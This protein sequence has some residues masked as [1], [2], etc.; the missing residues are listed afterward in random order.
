MYTATL[1]EERLAP[2]FI[3]SVST[4]K[5]FFFIK[6]NLPSMTTS[7]LKLMLN[8]LLPPTTKSGK[9]ISILEA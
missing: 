1:P 5:S 6:K 7:V 3:L 2:H 8:S 9:L 4:T